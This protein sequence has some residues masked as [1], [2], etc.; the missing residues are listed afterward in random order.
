M[1]WIS[2]NVNVGDLYDVL[3]ENVKDKTKTI[4]TFKNPDSNKYNVRC[5]TD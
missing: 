4:F 1:E 3:G 5:I 2:K